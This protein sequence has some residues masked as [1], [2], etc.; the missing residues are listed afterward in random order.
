MAAQGFRVGDRVR[1]LGLPPWLTHDLPADEQ[2]ELQSFVGRCAP[3][4]EID[5]YG[6]LWLGFGATTGRGDEARY[7]GHSFA[8]PPDFVEPAAG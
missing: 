2:V 7:S 3:I 8:V 5:A 1:L 6:Y 4:T